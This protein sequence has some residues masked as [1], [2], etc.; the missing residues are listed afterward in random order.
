[1]AEFTVRRFVDGRP[2]ATPPPVAAPVLSW[3]AAAPAPVQPKPAT[4]RGPRRRS[5]Y[6]LQDMALGDSRFFPGDGVGQY[7]LANRISVT[8]AIWHRSNPER[9]R[10]TMKDGGVWVTRTR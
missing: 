8:C 3:V 10:T 2:V 6:G 4:R 5:I 7:V 9:F 1:M